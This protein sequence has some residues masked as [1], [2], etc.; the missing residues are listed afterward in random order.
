MN[1]TASFARPI[2]ITLGDA[3]GIGPEI[4]VKLLA[5]GVSTST[6]VYGDAGVINTTIKRLGLDKTLKVKVL[7]S[8]LQATNEPHCIQVLNRWKELPTDLPIGRMSALAGRGAYEYLCQ[9]I[10][11]AQASR[12]RAIVTAPLN[13]EAMQ[14]GGAN[15]PGHTEI[16]A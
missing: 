10:D 8:P 6:V 3:A 12:L 1:D 14:A 2:G 4:I 5:K 15:Y 9:A 11:D 13:K 16:L 7:S